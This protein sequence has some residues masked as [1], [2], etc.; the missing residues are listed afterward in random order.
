M[1]INFMVLIADDHDL[2]LNGA[3]D[4]EGM[5][6]VKDTSDD[7]TILVQ[8]DPFLS[9][10]MAP[11]KR[12]VIR[13]GMV[14]SEE[15]IGETDMTQ[16]TEI[17]SLMERFAHNLLSYTDE[18]SVRQTFFPI[19]DEIQKN[20]DGKYLD[21][22]RF[23]RLIQE[24]YGKEIYYS[25]EIITSVDELLVGLDQLI[26]VNK[27]HDFSE[28]NSISVYL[29][30]LEDRSDFTL[31]ILGQQ[32]I[33]Q[34]DV[35]PHWHRLFKEIGEFYQANPEM[36]FIFPEVDPSLAYT[37]LVTVPT[38]INVG[39]TSPSNR[40]M[41]ELLGNPRE[42]YTGKCSMAVTGAL[43]RRMVLE[44]VGPFRVT[45]FDLAVASLREVFEE[46]SSYY[47]DL[48]AG[49]SSAGMLCCRYVRGSSSS[50][51]N[52]S[53]GTAID[54][55][56]NGKLDPYNDD[57]V[58]Y[59]LTLL[60]PIFN[61]H[62]WNW[63]V[64]FGHED[65]MHF[66]VSHEKLIEW[67][68]EGK[69]FAH[70]SGYKPTQHLEVGSRGEAV[71]ELQRKLNQLGYHLIA[72]G[73]FGNGTRVTVIDFQV[74]H[75]LAADGIVGSGTMKKIDQLLGQPIAK[76]V[77]QE[78][79]PI[80]SLGDRDRYVQI[81]QEHLNHLGM[82]IPEN[83]N[84]D[85]LTLQAVLDLQKALGLEESGLIDETLWGRLTSKIKSKAVITKRPLILQL[86]DAND[87]VMM[88]Q[89]DLQ[90]NGYAVPLDGYFGIEV[91]R[92]VKAIQE[93]CG[94]TATGEVDEETRRCIVS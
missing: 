45:G 26:M 39:L 35:A 13:N 48:V 91:E 74:K 22:Y 1:K 88:L 14:I 42:H 44:R 10:A 32:D 36:E 60:A 9:A 54:L 4:M 62:G 63:G 27:T 93:Q 5:L 2:H 64:T 51:S 46:A 50:I 19:Y 3:A 12:Y 65:G 87:E 33:N 85:K 49:L 23:V 56:I 86:G 59:G 41:L 57:K 31:Y 21:F 55:K 34:A 76:S 15:D 69:L 83:G 94:L 40:A 18:Y 66:E 78:S 73:V 67:K 29:P 89:S 6:S 58:Q 11:T 8:F 81:A 43:G 92:A 7:I 70:S 82:K 28:A 24:H 17:G 25:E 77:T 47:P 20:H 53:W 75:G 61:K 52:H 79:Y 38:D 84:F 71:K 72:D 90:E 37:D 30:I 80:L 16:L 68:E